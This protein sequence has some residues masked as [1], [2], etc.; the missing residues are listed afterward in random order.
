MASHRVAS[1]E[2][3]AAEY[4]CAFIRFTNG[5]SEM[6]KF[7]YFPRFYA[8]FFGTTGEP[9]IFRVPSRV[10]YLPAPLERC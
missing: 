7:K 4:N 3:K 9:I 5:N 8:I 2:L 1:C 10:A 6:V